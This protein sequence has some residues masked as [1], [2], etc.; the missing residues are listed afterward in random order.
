[1]EQW[2]GRVRGTWQ[3]T[4][5]KRT[6]SRARSIQIGG[7]GAGVSVG[8]EPVGAS[9][10]ERDEQDVQAAVAPDGRPPGEKQEIDERGGGDE[11]PPAPAQAAAPGRR[12]GASSPAFLPPGAGIP[13]ARNSALAPPEAAPL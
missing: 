9:G 3:V 7:F 5:A 4:S 13:A 10:V 1:M 2:D 11:D 8:A 6:P 12:F